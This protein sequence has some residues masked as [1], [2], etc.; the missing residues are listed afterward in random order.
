HPTLAERR[1]LDKLSDRLGEGLSER[2]Q[3]LYARGLADAARVEDAQLS[4]DM[5]ELA[6]ELL[7][8]EEGVRLILHE[9]GVAL[10][11]GRRRPEGIQE[12]VSLEGDG[13]TPPVLY[14]FDGEFWTDELDDLVVTVRDRCID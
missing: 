5:E 9:L 7:E 8:A 2:L 10:L 11:R 13:Q 12:R 6:Q 14:V 1:M 3:A 4:D